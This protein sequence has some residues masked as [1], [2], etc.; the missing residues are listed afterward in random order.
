MSNLQD[1][2]T[3]FKNFCRNHPTKSRN[4]KGLGCLRP[5]YKLATQTQRWDFPSWLF[6]SYPAS[7]MLYPGA[8]PCLNQTKYFQYIRTHLRWTISCCA[9]RMKRQRRTMFRPDSEDRVGHLFPPSWLR[10]YACDMTIVAEDWLKGTSSAC[11]PD[12]ILQTLSRVDMTLLPFTL[13]TQAIFTLIQSGLHFWKSDLKVSQTPAWIG[14]N[15]ARLVCW[16][17]TVGYI[18][19]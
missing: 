5:N 11:S 12:L 4:C 14:T 9:P 19:C 2:T 8:T 16:H 17:R 1:K 18:Y 13:K 15:S 6:A 7:C 10:K 3:R